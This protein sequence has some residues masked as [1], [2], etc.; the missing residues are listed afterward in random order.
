MLGDTNVQPMLPV[1]DL[2]EAKKFYEEKLGLKRVGEEPGAAVVYQ[3]GNGTLCVYL[4]RFAGTNQGTA[5]LWEVGDVEGT[6]KELKDKGVSFEHYDNLPETKRTDDVHR[7]GD[8][9]VA[10]FKDPDGNILSVQNRPAR[11]AKDGEGADQGAA[12]PSPAKPDEA[13]PEPPK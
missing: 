6:V 13:T 3:S 10:W 2:E 5:A 8:I 11:P 1:K 12:K 7:A 9:V 4:S